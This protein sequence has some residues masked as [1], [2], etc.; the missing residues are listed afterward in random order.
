MKVRL[1]VSEIQR[2]SASRRRQGKTV[3]LPAK[4][5]LTTTS[6]V[7]HETTLSLSLH[8]L[9]L[10]YLQSHKHCELV[11]HS[12]A[13]YVHHMEEKESGEVGDMVEGRPDERKSL[14]NSP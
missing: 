6:K 14:C 12:V 7:E 13:D 5:V 4:V 2:G 1:V 3:V 8:P 10:T 11:C 9:L